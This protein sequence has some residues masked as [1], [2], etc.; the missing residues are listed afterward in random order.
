MRTAAGSVSLMLFAGIW[1][2][3]QAD[4]MRSVGLDPAMSPPP[5]VL[6]AAASFVYP[7]IY[8]MAF[9]ALLSLNVLYE[10]KGDPR[11]LAEFAGLCFFTQIPFLLF[12]VAVPLL[13]DAPPRWE[14][15]IELDWVLV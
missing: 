7:T 13:L 5:W 4:M 11:R 1:S 12:L 3:P 9:L 10:G 15:H 6:V 8:G 14:C 2:D